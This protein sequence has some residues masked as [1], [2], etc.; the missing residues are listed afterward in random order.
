MDQEGE[1]EPA[2]KT[3]LCKQTA[4]AVDEPAQ[5]MLIIAPLYNHTLELGEIPYS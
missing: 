1:A 4:D 5:I 2:M 3:V